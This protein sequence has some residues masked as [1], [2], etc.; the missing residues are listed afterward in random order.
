M[1]TRSPPASSRRLEPSAA[2]RCIALVILRLARACRNA[3]CSM[4]LM[5][6][7]GHAQHQLCGTDNRNESLHRF[8]HR[9]VEMPHA[10]RDIKF[11][12]H[13]QPLARILT[14]MPS[15]RRLFFTGL[16]LRAE[17]AGPFTLRTAR[18]ICH[19]EEIV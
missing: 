11:S 13:R 6:L 17:A 8:E 3:A 2:R 18:R 16:F 7:L 4:S 9:R 1:P 10:K 12:L 19:I 15:L 14:T 5:F